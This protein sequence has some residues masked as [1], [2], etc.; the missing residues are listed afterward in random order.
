MSHFIGLIVKFYINI[1]AV[2]QRYNLLLFPEWR[3]DGKMENIYRF[4]FVEPF[5]SVCKNDCLLGDGLVRPECWL[6]LLNKRGEN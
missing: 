5:F 3:Q 1:P 4:I 6:V 2:N